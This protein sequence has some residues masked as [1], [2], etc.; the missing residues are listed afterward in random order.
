MPS[1]AIQRFANCSRHHR[2]VSEARETLQSR[3]LHLMPAFNFCSMRCFWEAY[4]GTSFGCTYLPTD[5]I[6]GMQ[7]EYPHIYFWSRSSG[8]G[9]LRMMY[10]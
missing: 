2:I 5:G 6:R 9:P 1:G 4:R 10:F 7:A 3:K 8:C